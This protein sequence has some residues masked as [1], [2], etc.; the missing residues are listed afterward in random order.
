MHEVARECKILTWLLQ[1]LCPEA[2]QSTT[3]CDCVPAQSVRSKTASYAARAPALHSTQ[4]VT[5]PHRPATGHLKQLT[6]CERVATPR[7]LRSE[8]ALL[9]WADL[10]SFQKLQDGY[11]S[12]VPFQMPAKEL[13]AFSVPVQPERIH[14]LHDLLSIQTDHRKSHTRSARNDSHQLIARAQMACLSCRP[15]FG[16]DDCHIANAL[17]VG[18]G[19]EN[20]GPGAMHPRSSVCNHVPFVR[21]MGLPLHPPDNSQASRGLDPLNVHGLHQCQIGQFFSTNEKLAAI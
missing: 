15:L 6:N 5:M 9:I 8:Q 16:L 17:V 2:Q 11:F 20:S 13:S 12:H 21:M 14:L 18:N 1:N 19:R 4:P 3:E 10:S 7:N